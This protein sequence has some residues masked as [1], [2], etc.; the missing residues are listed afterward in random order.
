MALDLFYKLQTF[1]IIKLSLLAKEYQYVDIQSLTYQIILKPLLINFNYLLQYIRKSIQKRYKP[2]LQ[3]NN[4]IKEIITI[5]VVTV[6]TAATNKDYV[7][8][9]I[10]K[11]DI[12]YRNIL[13]RSKKSLRLNLKISLRTA[14]RSK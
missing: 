6:V 5:T 3:I 8:L 13:K 11:K 2:F 9:Y 10:I 14:F 1:F 7:T 12:T 4:S